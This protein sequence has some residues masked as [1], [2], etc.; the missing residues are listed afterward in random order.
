MRTLSIVSG[1]TPKSDNDR[2]LERDPAGYVDGL[3]LYLYVGANPIILI[4][5]WG[6]DAVE[7]SKRLLAQSAARQDAG[8]STVI[9]KTT[10]NNGITRHDAASDCERDRLDEL[11][12]L[13]EIEAAAEIE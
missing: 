8:L 3:N 4:D 9:G 7:D 10:Y 6:L 11:L 5:P 1:S 13:A 2:W 12:R